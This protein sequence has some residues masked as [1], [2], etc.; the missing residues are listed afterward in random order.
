MALSDS[1]I[2]W[3]GYVAGQNITAQTQ[4]DADARAAARDA[5]LAQELAQNLENVSGEIDAAMGL[6]IENRNDPKSVKGLW[7]TLVNGSAGTTEM[8]WREVE[9]QNGAIF[10]KWQ[11][12]M[13]VEVDTVAD[14]G[15]DTVNIPPENVAAL[16]QAHQRILALQEHMASQLDGNGEPLFSDE[17]IRKE[18]WSPMVRSGLIPENMVPDKYSEQAIAFQGAMELYG[19]K[20]AAYSETHSK[21]MDQFKTG[22]RIAKE[23][24]TVTGSIVANSITIGNATTVA[25]KQAEVKELKQ[26]N[27]DLK[28]ELD[29]TPPP[30]AERIQEIEERQA[31]ITTETKALSADVKTLQQQTT[32]AQNATAILLGGLAGT[33]LVVDHVTSKEKDSLV[34]WMNTVEKALTITQTLVVKS[35]DSGMKA[36][37][38]SSGMTTHVTAAITASFAGVK[39]LPTLAM[40]IHEK[41]DNKRA[42]L[43]DR[44]VGNLAETVASSVISVS[45]RLSDEAATK[46]A[47][48]PDDPEVLTLTNQAASMQQVANGLRLGIKEIGTGYAIW[49]AIENGNTQELASLLGGAAVSAAFGFSSEAIYDA[50]RADVTSDDMLDKSKG[51]SLFAEAMGDLQESKQ[52]AGSAKSLKDMDAALSKVNSAALAGLKQGDTDP[53]AGSSAEELA[54]EI[55]AEADKRAQEQAK[56]D[57]REAFSPE[58]VAAMMEEADQELL[59]FEEM[60]S[61]AHPD[62]DITQRTPEEILQ[63]QQAIDRAMAKTAALRQKVDLL[64]G[65]TAGGAGVLAALV[66]GTAVVVAAQ[67]VAKDIYVLKKS[68]DTHNAWVQSMKL[69]FKAQSGSAAAIQNVLENAE[70]HLS[71]AAISLTLHTLQAGAAVAQ[72]MDPTGAATA[73]SAALSMADAVTEFGYKMHTEIAIQRGWNAYKDARDNPGNRKRAREALR[74]NSTLAKCC[75]A[76]GASIMGDPAAQQAIRATGLTV[77]ALQNDKDICVKLISYLENEL[78]Q[79]PTILKVVNTKDT[80]WHPGKPSLTLSSW[81]SFKGAAAASAEPLLDPSGSQS[82]AIDRLLSELARLKGWQDKTAIEAA[83]KEHIDALHADPDAPLPDSIETLLTTNETALD[84]TER[85]KAAF[86]VYAPISVEAGSPQHKGMV[87]VAASFATLARLAGVTASSHVDALKDYIK[88]YTPEPEPEPAD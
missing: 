3:I 8:N 46:K 85:C 42:K 21:G 59:G 37:G 32:H 60:Y 27:A 14:I 54:K 50:V 61:Q 45:G 24:V 67:K 53:L 11:M 20:I 84:L 70:I 49:R 33:E 76:Y 64:N 2:Q 51:E 80:K 44:L 71:H 65:I 30:S 25:D 52:D 43:I 28:A 7:L 23:V 79:D 62:P 86:E 56:A 22:M 40:A 74:L 35:V 87:E 9:D 82:P 4:A 55:E 48:N 19:D 16:T 81:V 12:K 83:I 63:A 15:A 58:A 26:E 66:P 78:N 29:G 18:L 47:A 5:F 68:V 10:N 69:A 38:A 34:K 88:L 57:L 75:I 1:D 39:M 17:D 6:V 31:A 13:D 36:N 72:L 73:T 41:D 77:A